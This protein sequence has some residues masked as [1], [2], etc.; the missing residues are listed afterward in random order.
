MK[1][2]KLNRSN[3]GNRKVSRKYKL[4]F[5]GNLGN[6]SPNS[7]N[8]VVTNN[9]ANNTAVNNAAANN[10]D[11]NKDNNS[12]ISYLADFKQIEN[13]Y[14][15][16]YAK[17]A[18]FNQKKVEQFENELSELEGENERAPN[19]NKSVDAIYKYV[20]SPPEIVTEKDLKKMATKF[21]PTNKTSKNDCLEEYKKIKNIRDKNWWGN[22]IVQGFKGNKKYVI[23]I[24]NVDYLDDDDKNRLEKSINIGKKMG[25]VGVGPKIH[26]VFY[27]KNKGKQQI[28]IV[29]DFIN[30]GSLST[31]SD[32]N[33]LTKQLKEKIKKKIELMHKNNVIH[34][35]L[36]QDHILV[37]QEKG[38]IDFFLTSFGGSVRVKD[39]A[40]TAKKEDIS[41]LEWMG[42]MDERKLKKLVVKKMVYE[43]MISVNV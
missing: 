30:K 5:G 32:K 14:N 33:V 10:T 9:A 24:K 38:K 21:V 19:L 11:A 12:P 4:K 6:N 41:S 39:L 31:W 16:E 26:N 25:K 40:E 34:N 17:V 27:C 43:N 35:N 37:Q 18:N 28:F 15:R 36:W 22:E 8:N 2:Q 7:P 3:N 1:S 20:S 42:G 29:M 23:K 13:I